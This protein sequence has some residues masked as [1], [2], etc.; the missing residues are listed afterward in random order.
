MAQLDWGVFCSP[1]TEYVDKVGWIESICQ[2]VGAR[3]YSAAA[4]E[5]TC[6]N[7]T[8]KLSQMTE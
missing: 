4:E 2:S 8:V 3:S 1:S 5:V 7:R 6:V